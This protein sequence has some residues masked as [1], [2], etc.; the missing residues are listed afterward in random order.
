MILILLLASAPW[1]DY[2][3]AHLPAAAGQEAAVLKQLKKQRAEQK[4]LALL[5]VPRT[6]SADLRTAIDVL[7]LMKPKAADVLLGE[8][9]KHPD[10][11][12][13]RAAAL[14]LALLGPKRVAAELI[15]ALDDP[16]RF[17]RD[18]VIQ[19]LR[20]LGTPAVHAAFR[21]RLGK[22]EDEMLRDELKTALSAR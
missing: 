11:E 3:R 9:L 13:R 6:P 2:A 8:T 18:Y 20:P 4:A 1:L 15:V 17:V 16:D 10:A 22:E 12:V 14:A 19:A 7:R 21:A 5:S